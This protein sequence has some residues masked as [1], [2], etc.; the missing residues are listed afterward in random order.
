MSELLDR[1]T[2]AR[3]HAEGRMERATFQADYRDNK[4]LVRLLEDVRDAL[5]RPAEPA[6]ILH[7]KGKV[8]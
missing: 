1:I 2:A 7:I 4:E 8:A 6:K 3:K 5:S